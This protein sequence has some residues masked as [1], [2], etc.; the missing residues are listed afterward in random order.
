MLACE[1]IR[2]QVVSTVTS[3]WEKAGTSKVRQ[4]LNSSL[5]SRFLL[6]II[7][8]A[9][10]LANVIVFREHTYAY[11]HAHAHAHTRAHTLL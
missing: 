6:R 4:L 11:A 5:G 9:S 1:R 3:I 10:S 7:S 8:I 2:E